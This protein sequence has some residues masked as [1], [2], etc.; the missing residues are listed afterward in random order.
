MKAKQSESTV[1][2]L[3]SRLP[4][5]IWNQIFSIRYQSPHEHDTSARKCSLKVAKDHCGEVVITLVGPK[6][7]SN[8]SEDGQYHHQS[9]FSNSESE[10]FLLPMLDYYSNVIPTRSETIRF[11]A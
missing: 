8:M 11:F 7:E 2:L 10:R 3:C 9:N 1:V 6:V 5:S 4:V